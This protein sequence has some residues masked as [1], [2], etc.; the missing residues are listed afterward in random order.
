MNTS[1]T[2]GL[3]LGRG[4]RVI[5]EFSESRLLIKVTGS[6]VLMKLKQVI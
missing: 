2:L 4:K 5:L 3:V 6:F 1:D